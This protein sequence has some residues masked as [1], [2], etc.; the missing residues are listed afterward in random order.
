MHR[1]SV[2]CAVYSA[3]CPVQGAQCTVYSAAR[4]VQHGVVD[5]T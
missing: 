3:K 1:V 4:G 2:Q 5:S